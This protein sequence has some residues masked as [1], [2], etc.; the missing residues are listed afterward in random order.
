M[1]T[2]IYLVRHAHSS[3]TPDELVRPLSSKGLEAAEK[4]TEILV[5]KDIDYIISSP[6]KR[7]IQTVE[8][9]SKKINK[10]IIIEDNFRE[11]L[12]A[13]KPVEDFQGAIT[14]VW[15][16]YTFSWEG[17]E[18]NIVAQKRGVKALEHIMKK[19]ED[20]NISIG[21]HGNIMTLI[22]NYYDSKYD[23]EFWKNLEMPDI[24]RLKFE[25]GRFLEAHKIFF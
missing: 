23:F 25:E 10:K 21:T 19:Y 12:L 15:D 4:V 6:Y 16:D 11:R 18:S 5:N 9:L 8:G 3:Y 17:G 13:K 14:K 2:T 1:V 24:Y 7:A 22:M 20:A